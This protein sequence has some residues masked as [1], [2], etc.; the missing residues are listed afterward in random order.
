MLWIFYTLAAIFIIEPLSDLEWL[1]SCDIT[2]RFKDNTYKH[3]LIESSDVALFNY[4]ISRSYL[5]SYK[6]SI[7]QVDHCS[8]QLHREPPWTSARHYLAPGSTRQVAMRTHMRII[9]PNTISETQLGK[10]PEGLIGL[11]CEIQ[12]SMRKSA[13]FLCI[14]WC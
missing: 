8:F 1:R 9:I 2:D 14:L 5:W 11:E 7:W 4:L 3:V 13:E 6:K 12:V 10:I